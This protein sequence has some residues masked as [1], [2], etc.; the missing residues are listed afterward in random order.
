MQW[1]WG[2]RGKKGREERSLPMVEM[3]EGEGIPNAERDLI[4]M[5]VERQGE[6]EKI[7]SSLFQVGDD[8]RS[9]YCGVTN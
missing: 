7:G 3:T 5:A 4:V 6:K 2:V 1:R 8:I 9:V